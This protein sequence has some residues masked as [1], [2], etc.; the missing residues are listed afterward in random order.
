MGFLL[1]ARD[2][3]GGYGLGPPPDGMPMCGAGA[4]WGADRSSP[5]AQMSAD[6]TAPDGGAASGTAEL[7][8]GAWGGGWLGSASLLLAGVAAGYAVAGWRAR[9]RDD[10]GRFRAMLYSEK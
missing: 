9:P 3:T 10:A 2:A 6:G 8:D 4:A 5:V 1:S 7:A